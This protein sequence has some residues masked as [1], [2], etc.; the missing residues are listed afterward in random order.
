M[1]NS[2]T[3]SPF[4]GDFATAI[5]TLRE[6]LTTLEFN[7]ALDTLKEANDRGILNEFIDEAEYSYYNEGADPMSAFYFATAELFTD[8]IKNF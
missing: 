7:T 1:Q 8:S 2:Y 3:T 5:K 4:F 6:N